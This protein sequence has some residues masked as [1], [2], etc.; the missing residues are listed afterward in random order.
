MLPTSLYEAARLYH[1][2]MRAGEEIL[3]LTC[4]EGWWSITTSRIVDLIVETV[5]PSLLR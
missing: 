5:P 4:C 1:A 2:R 3:S